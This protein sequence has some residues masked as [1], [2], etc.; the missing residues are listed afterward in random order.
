MKASA[1]IS[2]GSGDFFI[3]EIELADPQR[4]EVVVKIEAAGVCHTDHDH[5]ADWKLNEVMGHEGAGVVAAVGEGVIAVSVGDPVLLNWAMPCGACFQCAREAENL[6]EQRAVV[7]EARVTHRNAPIGRSFGLGTMSTHA[8]VTESALT[9]IEVPIPFASAA[10]IGCGVMT[11]Y[12]SVLNVARV[13]PGS[14]V[15]VLGAGGVGMSVIQAATIAGAAS[16]IAVDISAERLARARLFGA[17]HLIQAQVDDLGLLGA[18]ARVKEL[19]ELRGAD[20]AFECTAV[21]ELGSAPLAMIRNGGTAIGVSGIEQHIDFDMELFEWDKV[22]INPLYGRCSPRRDFPRI[23]DLYSAGDWK[24]DE[25]VTRTYPLKELG[26]A[27]ADMLE[28]TIVKG[29]V[30]MAGREPN[31]S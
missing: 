31:H 30:T 17:H 9:R 21:P 20:F 11:G 12:G 26:Q 10:I 25:M 1:A 19:T 4:G 16:I 23:L 24:L 18:A 13:T 28:G 15:V 22:Y 2:D 5:M 14:S 7:P 27:F 8:I 29:V 3:D 6:C